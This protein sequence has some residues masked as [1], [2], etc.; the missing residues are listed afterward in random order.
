MTAID[1]KTSRQRVA[2]QLFDAAVAS[3]DPT[4]L[5]AQYLGNEPNSRIHVVGAGKASAS[6]ALAVEQAWPNAD[7]CGLVIT[8]YGTLTP[9]SKIELIEARHPVP[10]EQGLVASRKILAL[11]TQLGSD[12]TLLCLISG[13]GSALMSMSAGSVTLAEKQQINKALL[14]SGAAIDEMNCVR[15]HLSAIKGG[16]LALAAHPAKVITLAVSDVPGDDF[17][18]IASGPT[19]QDNTT[20]AQAMEIL[21]RYK[22]ETPESVKTLLNQAPRNTQ[23]NDDVWA[24]TEA[25][26]IATPQQSLEAAAALAKSSGYHPLILGDAIEG[27]ARDVAKVMA[28]M[29]KQVCQYGQPAP[30]PVALI[31][32]GETTVTLRG[33][34]GRGGRNGEFLLSFA[35]E[36]GDNPRV[37]ALACDTD[38]IDGSEDN[39]GAVWDSSVASAAAAKKLN[40]RTYLDNHDAYSFF[41]ACDAL[42][43]TGPTFTNVNDFRVVLID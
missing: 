30:A 22:I 12:D 32:G 16:R 26:M 25:H 29:T 27:E 4:K 17:S 20:A 37:T 15:K 39:A 21:S 43:K 35:N 13:G 10:D 6:M 5:V 14:S 19:V 8:P 36:I 1:K 33:K 40:S 7:I 3:A 41:E 31:S 38:G 18:V 24:N 42:V 9:T 34:G 2:I 28:A 11:A 23:G